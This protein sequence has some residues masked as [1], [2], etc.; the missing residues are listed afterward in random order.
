MPE[1]DPRFDPERFEKRLENARTKKK[2]SLEKQHARFLEAGFE[3][4]KDWWGSSVD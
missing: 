2:E 1:P 4:N 3:P